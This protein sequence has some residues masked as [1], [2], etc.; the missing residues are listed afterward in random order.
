V[1][2]GLFDF[3]RDTGQLRRDGAAVKLAPQPARVLGLLLSRPGELVS[4]DEFRREL[5]GDDTFVD[6]ERGLNFCIAQVRS[7]LGDSSENPRFIQT[8]PRRGYRFIAPVMEPAPATDPEVTVSGTVP[9]SGDSPRDEGL[10]PNSGTGVARWVAAVAVAGIALAIWWAWSARQAP[11]PA[12]ARSGGGSVRIAVLP[13]VNLTGDTALD[14]LTDGFTDEV[15]T[16]LGAAAGDRLAVIAR[17]SAMAYRDS[18]K[19]VAD[20]ARELDVNYVVEG[21]LRREGDALRINSRL[22]SVATQTAIA[23]FEEMLDR[24]GTARQTQ[25]AHASIRLARN[26]ASELLPTPLGN[27]ETRPAFTSPAA[28][29]RFLHANAAF[30]KGTAKDV[31]RAVVELDQAVSRDPTFAAA[32]ARL[33]EAHHLLAM[34]GS[35]SPADS[36]PGAQRA[37]QQAITLAPGQATS[38]LAH[39]P[40]AA[41]VPL[42]TFGR[43]R[44]LR[45]RISPQPEPGGGASRLRLGARRPR[46]PR[47]CHQAHHAGARS[48]SAVD[49]REQRR[50]VVVSAPAPTAG[51]HPRL[52]THA[53]DRCRLA[54]SAGVSRTLLHRAAALH[55]RVS[56]GA[57]DTAGA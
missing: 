52:S 32:W 47:R 42:A 34:M 1:S 28:W 46:A 31:R 4:R 6:F 2:F 12:E 35:A 27:S 11:S 48:R 21:T 51:R 8:V 29:D 45:T 17:T 5:W 25:E 33:A 26:V 18:R 30:N 39:G 56:S 57:R 49:T 43:S 37:A 15:I 36:Y 10:S 3:D 24:A 54:R 13:V 19:S 38:H 44:V 41:L 7:A 40:R 14:E 50:G 16:Q 22:V 20:I 53:G 9:G 55:C 23:Q